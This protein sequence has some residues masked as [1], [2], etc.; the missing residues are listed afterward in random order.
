MHDPFPQMIEQGI[1]LL[2]PSV[3]APSTKKKNLVQFYVPAENTSV[4]F[5]AGPIPGVRMVTDHHVHLTARAPLTTISLGK[6]AGDGVGGPDGLQVVTEG[7]KNEYV[8]LKTWETYTQDASLVYGAKKSEEV[9]MDWDERC[10]SS[11]TEFV[12]DGW[13]QTCTANKSESVTGEKKSDTE[14]RILRWLAPL[15]LYIKRREMKKL[16][17]T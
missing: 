15:R 17:A 5:G 14:L 2:T 10:H 16:S 4:D 3:A 6:A 1:A 7:N 9:T 13:V 11:K 12:R 8:L